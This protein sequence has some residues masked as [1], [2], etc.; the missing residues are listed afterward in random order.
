[1][2]KGLL[3][4]SPRGGN[5][6]P[7]DRELADATRAA[8]AVGVIKQLA[9]PPAQ[10]P[11]LAALL[12]P[13]VQTLGEQLADQVRRTGQPP[14]TDDVTEKIKRLLDLKTLSAIDSPPPAPQPT[15]A[16]EM[17]A[18]AQGAASIHQGAAETALAQA[19]QERQRRAEAEENAAGQ[20]SYAR[21]D[22][23]SKWAI[24][25][26]MTETQN[27]TILAMME[28]L[29][30][31]AAAAR[32]AQYTQQLAAINEKL[33]AYSAAHKAELATTERLHAADLT[34]KEKE[35]AWALEKLKLEHALAAAPRSDSPQEVMNR[36]WAEQQSRLFKIEA[37]D[38]EEEARQK[39]E[40]GDEITSVLSSINEHI[41]PN[42]GAFIA[43]PGAPRRSIPPV[44]PP[45][46]EAP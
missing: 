24:V 22:E 19:E 15:S 16:T 14:T 18:L 12:A 32:E 17:M 20:A 2:P 36:H 9:P 40:R 21:Q 29:S 7:L 28:R 1:M 44:P 39:R 35:A 6:S 42:L 13:V 4:A 37:D 33:D 5:A 3:G 43:G 26:K 38:K 31:Q 10:D 8:K 45:P 46:E 25:M 34:A 23:A 27:D 30:T 41:L 11:S